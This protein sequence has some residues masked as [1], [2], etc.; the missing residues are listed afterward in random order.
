MPCLCYKTE[1]Y[2]IKKPGDPMYLIKTNNAQ[3]PNSEYANV[4]VVSKQVLAEERF[5]RLKEIEL[6]ERIPYQESRK[7]V[8]TPTSGSLSNR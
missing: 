4:E 1:H 3:R 5:K 7:T 2:Y 6:E 8:I